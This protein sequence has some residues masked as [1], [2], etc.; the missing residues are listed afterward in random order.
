MSKP[1]KVMFWIL[2]I[3]PAVILLQTLFFKFTAAP[4]S[5]DLFRQLGM[6]PWGRIGIGLLELAAAVMLLIPRTVANGAGLTVLLMLGALG[7]HVTTLGFAGDM[8][9]LA[10]MAALT[11]VC[12]AA[13]AIRYRERFFCM[14]CATLK[15]CRV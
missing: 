2:R 15:R 12:A 5:V 11:L 6:E 14:V 4:E 1:A 13:V 10:A 9:T 3:V 7:S 8:G